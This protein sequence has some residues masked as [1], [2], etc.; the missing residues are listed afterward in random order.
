MNSSLTSPITVTS[1]P[2][3]VYRLLKDGIERGEFA[4]GAK[5]VESEIAAQLNVSRTPIREAISRLAAEGLVTLVPRRGAFVASL[6][7]TA[8]REL[9]EIREALEGLAAEL[10]L[11]E[12]EDED[13]EALEI[14]LEEFSEALARDDYQVYFEIDRSFHEQIVALSGN[15]RLQELFQLIDGSIQVTR[16]MHCDSGE[17]SEVALEEHKQIVAALHDRDRAQVV[18]LVRAH[19]RRVKNDLLDENFQ[20]SADA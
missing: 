6:D 7:R 15:S 12:L 20:S 17:I 10:A 19:I 5:L 9:Y 8:I 16:W 11:P 13:I 4:S 14:T 1:L 3:Q 2:E 18:K